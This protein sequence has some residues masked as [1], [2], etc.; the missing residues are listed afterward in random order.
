MI[1]HVYTL[2][3]NEEIILPFFLRHYDFA[4]RI[5]VYD[6]YSTDK[7]IEICNANPKVE[8]RQYDSG[9]EIRDDLYLKIKNNAWKQ[10]RGIADYV[11]VVDIDEFLY[12]DNILQKLSTISKTII[13]PN[14]YEMVSDEIPSGIEQ[15]YNYIP[16]GA[17]SPGH[18]KCV[19][20]NPD[21]IQEINYRP[22]CHSCKPI[23]NI[24]L[25]PPDGTFKLLHYK[26]LSVE[27]VIDR[28]RKFN[29]RLSEFNIRN[30]YGIQ[31]TYTENQL[32]TYHSDIKKHAVNVIDFNM[33]SIM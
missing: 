28:Y 29:E 14:G 4:D 1:I 3:Y 32:R 5:F 15:I 11:I 8:V 10:S 17:T 12:S 9:G 16:N 19:I 18:N 26:H 6:N 33:K 31:Y 24:I 7:S 20:F 30:G 27:Y 25:H 2:C 13:E 23:G 22:G 21:A